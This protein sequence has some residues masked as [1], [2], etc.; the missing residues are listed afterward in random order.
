M[1]DASN[2]NEGFRCPD[3]GIAFSLQWSGEP[4]VAYCPF[5]GLNIRGEHIMPTART[6]SPLPTVRTLSEA[7]LEA[8]YQKL[9]YARSVLTNEDRKAIEAARRA[10]YRDRDAR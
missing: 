3:C 6:L 4:T 2:Q 1:S 8:I 9:A 7:D 5:C 10:V